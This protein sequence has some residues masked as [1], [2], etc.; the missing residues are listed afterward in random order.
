MLGRRLLILVAVLMGLTALAA[1]V[2]PRESALERS[3][4][5]TPTPAPALTPAPTPA[6]PEAEPRREDD[7]EGETDVP[8][9]PPLRRLE[10]DGSGQVVDARVGQ[11][12]RLAISADETATVQIGTGGRIEAIDPDSPARYDLLFTRPVREEIRVLGADLRP[13]RTIGV[14]RVR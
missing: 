2:A 14:V 13:L 6:D 9:E 5:A 12:V 4:R 8:G 7:V 11:R 10:A 1:L 3:A